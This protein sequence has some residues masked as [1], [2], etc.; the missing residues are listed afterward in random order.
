MIK[1]IN[2]GDVVCNELKHDYGFFCFTIPGAM[3][4]DRDLALFS[5]NE[6]KPFVPEKVRLRVGP[7]VLER[8]LKEQADKIFQNV[9]MDNGVLLKVYPNFF[10]KY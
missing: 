6:K 3:V 9:T 4:R 5:V 1:M 2:C 10:L 8:C 7:F